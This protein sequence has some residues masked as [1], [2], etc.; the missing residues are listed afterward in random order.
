[1]TELHIHPSQINQRC[2]KELC[3]AGLDF[4]Y[5]GLSRMSFFGFDTTLPKDRPPA[6]QTRGIFENPDPF[7]DV[8]RA[9]AQGL[10]DDDDDT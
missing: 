5:H 7:A 6:T 4:D 10:H 2:A 3:I 8:A 9:T 1:L